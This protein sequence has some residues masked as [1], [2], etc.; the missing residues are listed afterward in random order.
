M[1]TP[2]LRFVCV[3]DD[4]TCS[5]F[6]SRQLDSIGFVWDG[7]AERARLEEQKSQEVFERNFAAYVK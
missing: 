7:T 6:F 2:L 1:H 5:P 3:H 4:A